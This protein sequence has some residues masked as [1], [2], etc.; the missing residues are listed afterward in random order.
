MTARLPSPGSDDGT[1]GTILNDFLNQAHNPDGTIKDVGVV[2][3]KADDNTVIHNAG[4]ETIAGT[5]TFNSSPVVPTPTLGSQSANKTYVDSTVSS[6]AP[7]ATTTT[8]GI[9]QLTNDLGGT[10]TAPTVPGLATKADDSAVVHKA[11]AETI[12]GVKTFSS[13]PIVP[14]PT[15]STE[16]A[17]KGY[18]DGVASS[19]STPDADATTKGKL[20]LAG[21]LSGTATSPTVAKVNG[22]TLPGTAPSAA[23]QVLTAT[24]ASATSWATP[25]AGV[26]LDSTSADIAPLGTQ[27]A[28]STGKAA[29]AGHVHTMPRL[30]Q[31]ATPTSDISFNSH[32][33]IN[34]A[35]PTIAQD[36][37]TKAYVD[38]QVTSIAPPPMLQPL[39]RA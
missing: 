31:A 29:D 19:G 2:A 34:V 14:T 17:N 38:N 21:D 35:D 12:A 16:T 6:G 26:M 13:A 30:D 22:V 25:A 33:A 18:V 9:V 23:G 3:A 27:A 8:K 11:N 37:A 10:A 39:Q 32:K 15:V 24:S 4:N 28:G 36:A 20:Q 5:K 7:D 1:W